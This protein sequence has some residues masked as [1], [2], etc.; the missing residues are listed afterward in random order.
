VYENGKPVS[1]ITEGDSVL[2]FNFRADRAREISIALN[3]LETIP[4]LTKDLNLEYVTMTEY[5]ED[6]PFRTLFPKLHLN[7]ILGEVISKSKLR[8]LRIAET[9]KYAHVTF[10]FN[11]GDEKK[12]EGEDR[13]LVPSPKVATYDLQPEMSVTDRAI[14]E[15]EKKIHDLII[16]N[17]ANCDMVGHT[18]IFSAASKAVET[19]D[20]CM[21]KI[22]ESA[23]KNDYIL[24]VTADHGNAEYMM[25][26]EVPFTAH[27]KN[28]VPFLISDRDLK[29]KEGKLGDIAPTILKIMGLKIPAEMTGE[30]LFQE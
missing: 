8:Q 27:T 9:E 5:R 24:I 7:N 2:F 12:F 22:R 17:F 21:G 3:N 15:I 30:I 26:G 4:F 25:D 6:F 28:R 14:E 10:F 20:A 11:G 23:Q 29:L 13:I 1:K 16:L 18:G 19:V